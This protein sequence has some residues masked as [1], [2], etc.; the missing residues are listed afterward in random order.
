MAKQ[1]KFQKVKEIIERV[2]LGDGVQILTFINVEL[3]K[4]GY[5]DL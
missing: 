5:G 2:K 4:V 1:R 3:V